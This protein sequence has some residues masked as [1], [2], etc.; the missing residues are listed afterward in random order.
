MKRTMLAALAALMLAGTAGA[1]PDA[2]DKRVSLDLRNATAEEAFKSLA[3]V[4]GVQIAAE[5]LSGDVTLELENV[6]VRTI[7][8]ALCDNLGCK[9]DLQAGNPPKLRI[10]PLP[11]GERPAPPVKPSAAALNAAIDLKVTDATVRDVLET[12]GQIMSAKTFIDSS[13]EGKVSLELDNTPLRDVLDI[14]CKTSKCTWSFDE[15]RGILSVK[16]KA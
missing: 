10:T 9:W 15:D 12:V 14:I 6:R 16:P 13:I 1:A 8:T 11:G 5:G 4:A 7:L 2:L 3:R